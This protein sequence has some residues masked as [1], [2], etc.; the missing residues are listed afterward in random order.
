MSKRRNSS[1]LS[2]VAAIDKP[3]GMTSHDVINGC[4]KALGESRI[5]HAGTLDPFATGVLVVC[6]GPA[7]RLNQYISCDNKSYEARIVFGR[8]TDTDDCTGNVTFE[9]KPSEELFEEGFATEFL[10]TLTGPQKQLP[11]VY[12]AIK[13]KGKKSYEQARKGNIIELCPRDINIYSMNLSGTGVD[14]NGMLYWDVSCDVSKGTY[15]RAIARDIGKRLGCG[16]HLGALRRTRS[17]SVGA[18]QC[19]SVEELGKHRDRA[20]LDPA[21]LLGFRLIMA[22]FGNNREELRN[23]HPLCADQNIY[24]KQAGID[25][26]CCT[27]G[28]FLT[29]ESPHDGELFS[30][31]TGSDLYGIYA[32]D[33]GTERF[34]AKCVFPEGVKRPSRVF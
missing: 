33:A 32:W 22:D 13:V 11:P 12:S 6:I 19:I 10:K 3:Y 18:D 14:V 25:D 28:L 23:G 1:G 7:A 34:A 24:L 8:A 20:C 29:D 5:G 15:I 31:V 4:R 16:A 2:F 27:S 21:K 26:A 9:G 30:I 17:G